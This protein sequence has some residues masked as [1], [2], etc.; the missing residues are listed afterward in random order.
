VDPRDI[1]RNGSVRIWLALLASVFL[2]GALLVSSRS[3]TGAPTGSAASRNAQF[4]WMLLVLGAV[5]FFVFWWLSSRRLRSGAGTPVSRAR[6][7]FL[8]RAVSAEVMALYGLVLGF[9]RPVQE[10]LVFFACALVGFVLS[11]PTR[12]AWTEAVRIAESPGP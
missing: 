6:A 3:R 12:E 1:D 4:F 9:S 8:L 10:P 2:Y 7:F 5:Q 11:F